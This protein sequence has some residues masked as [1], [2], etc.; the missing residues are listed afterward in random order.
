M[1]VK[2]YLLDSNAVTSLINNRPPFI[3]KLEIVRR[4]GCRIG[5]CEPVVAELLFGLEMSSSRNA[6]ILRLYR[7]L[8]LIRCWPFDRSASEVYGRTSAELRRRG[9]QM[10]VIDVMLA[11]TAL[12]LGNCTVVTTDSDLSDIP[13]LK[14]ENWELE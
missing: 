12:S 8:R 5:T 3:A 14:V 4:Q 11:A 9:R 1:G 6:N 7:G 2:R 13:C 10:Q